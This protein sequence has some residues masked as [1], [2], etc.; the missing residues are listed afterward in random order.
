MFHF[1]RASLHSLLRRADVEFFDPDLESRLP[2][3]RQ[4]YALGTMSKKRSE[5]GTLKKVLGRIVAAL[6]VGTA[7]G[8]AAALASGEWTGTLTMIGFGVG[9]L[10]GAIFGFGPLELVNS[11]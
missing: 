8:L 3:E 2:H 6:V 7:M 4:C 11:I 9:A 5:S 1:I 10:L